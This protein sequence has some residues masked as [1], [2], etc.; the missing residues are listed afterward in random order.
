[1]TPA[2]LY[3]TNFHGWALRQANL[4]RNEKYAELDIE[5]LIEEIEAM[6]KRDQ[7]KVERR[8]AHILEHL[9]KLMAQPHSQAWRK[10]RQSILTQR[11]EL[12]R[13]FRSNYVLR[14]QL[15]DFIDDSYQDARKLAAEGLECSVDNFSQRCPWSPEQIL[16]HEFFPQV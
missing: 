15:A 16:D 13:F 6:A 1:M 11:L 10:W 7:R 12:A 14:A 4:L 9:L 3:D 8:L 2:A 5:H